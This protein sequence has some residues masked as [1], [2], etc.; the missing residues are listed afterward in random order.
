MNRRLFVCAAVA[1][2][3]CASVPPPPPPPRLVTPADAALG[4]LE[5]LHLA[6]SDA[7]GLTIRVASNACT[8]KADWTFYVERR[9]KDA[10]LAFG[11]K[12]V[13]ACKGG[14]GQVDLTFTWAELGLA[15]G[16]EVILL[17]PLAR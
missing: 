8:A 9:G 11:R 13:D 17:N 6:W 16:A 3:G 4:E 2:C 15:H 14:P 5:P 10:R 1:L 12:A 7:R